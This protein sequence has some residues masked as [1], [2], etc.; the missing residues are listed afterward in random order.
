MPN[1]P[2]I[3]LTRNTGCGSGR[4][5][6]LYTITNGGHTWP[7]GSQYL[8]ESSVGK[9]SKDINANTEIWKFFSAHPL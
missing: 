3:S 9:V 2:S 6:R 7:D 8:P 4:E 5:V 1:L